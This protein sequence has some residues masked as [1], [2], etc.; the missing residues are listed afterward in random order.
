MTAFETHILHHC[1]L[2]IYDCYSGS[3]NFY[4]D[5]KT[6]VSGGR[7]PKF[8]I[9]NK[10]S[11]LYCKYNLTPLE[12][13]TSAEEVVIARAYLVVTILKLKPNNSF[14]PGTYRGVCGHSFLLPQNLGPLLTLLPSEITSVDDVV[15]VVWAYK[16]SLQPEQLSGFVS[17]R[18]YCIIGALQWLVA[19]NPL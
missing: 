13:L 17:L 5:C 19:N 15:R 1:D 6:C 8:D 10:M 2:D 18:K 3:F 4:H 9:S 14:N 12:D 16:T 7:E 11:K